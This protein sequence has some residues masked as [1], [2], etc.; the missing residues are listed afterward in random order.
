LIL[1]LVRHGDAAPGRPGEPDGARPLTGRGHAQAQAAA[2]FLLFRD[3]A[4]ERIL[5]S[6][7]R[8]AVETATPIAAAFGRSAEP[9]PWL[10]SGARPEDLANEL[11]AIEVGRVALVGHA[12][13]V[14]LL[15]AFLAAGAGAP[16][17]PIGKGGI[18]ILEASLPYAPGQAVLREVLDADEIERLAPPQ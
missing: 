12:P 16:E 14:G 1:T 15:A 17:V 18:A 13:D 3:A 2:H 11:R 4:L 8:R 7:L 5:T 9:V 6:P 10:T